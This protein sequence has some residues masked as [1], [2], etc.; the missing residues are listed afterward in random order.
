MSLAPASNQPQ[1]PAPLP[2]ETVVPEAGEGTPAVTDHAAAAAVE[3]PGAP[4]PAS[5]EV[6]APVVAEAG[7][8]GYPAGADLAEGA[9]EAGGVDADA[10]GADQTPSS[11]ASS[12]PTPPSSPSSLSLPS[13]GDDHP[14]AG[15]PGSSIDD[16]SVLL[17]G[18]WVYVAP[19]LDEWDPENPALATVHEVSASA[20]TLDPQNDR[21]LLT[22]P[23]QDVGRRIRRMDSPLPSIADNEILAWLHGEVH[24]GREC[25]IVDA[26]ANGE[27]LFASVAYFTH[28][29]TAQHKALRRRICEFM[30]AHSAFFMRLAGVSPAGWAAYLTRMRKVSTWGT[31]VELVAAAILFRADVQ[32]VTTT[33]SALAVMGMRDLTGHDL[34]WPVLE[35]RAF[36][37]VHAGSPGH[38]HYRPVALAGAAARGRPNRPWSADP[39]TAPPALIDAAPP[40][41]AAPN[42][43]SSQEA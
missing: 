28:G 37:L 30:K 18:V 34:A 32:V 6:A 43:E 14:S 8:A 12:T 17:P 31:D 23:I 21:P 15:V 29:D 39:A 7:R 11:G 20:I 22:I 24:P 33:G 2:E 25:S 27:C 26:P 41:A 40:S 13:D 4:A 10:S 3:P 35:S 42:R 19:E 16:L 38:E 1:E 5:G 36:T 9:S